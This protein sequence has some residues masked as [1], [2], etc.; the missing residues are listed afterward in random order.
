MQSTVS[1]LG[2]YLKEMKLASRDTC[3]SRFTAASHASQC[4]ISLDDY[5]Q[6]GDKENV[7]CTHKGALFSHKEER[8]HETV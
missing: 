7:G 1:L 5:D 6:G 4:G 2:V 3:T 8:N